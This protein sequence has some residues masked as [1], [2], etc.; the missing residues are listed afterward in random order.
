LSETA[1]ELVFA[2]LIAGLAPCGAC[3]VAPVLIQREAGYARTQTIT[4]HH[5]R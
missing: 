5:H 1:S 4:S 2:D 3:M